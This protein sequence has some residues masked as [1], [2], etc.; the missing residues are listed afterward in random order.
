MPQVPHSTLLAWEGEHLYPLIRAAEVHTGRTDEDIKAGALPLTCPVT[1]PTASPVLSLTVRASLSTMEGE[2]IVDCMTV[3][4]APESCVLEW[5]PS[6][7]SNWDLL[8]PRVMLLRHGGLVY[9]GQGPEPGSLDTVS[10]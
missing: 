9:Q 6:V 4:P 3:S 5:T 10:A 8:Q 2:V 1:L 7:L